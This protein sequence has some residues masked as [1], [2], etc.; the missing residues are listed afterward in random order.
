MCTHTC[1][2][3]AADQSPEPHSS[4]MWPFE[5]ICVSS[6][7]DSESNATS[8]NP[9]CLTP[10]PLPDPSHLGLS[11]HQRLFLWRVCCLSALGHQPPYTSDLRGEHSPTRAEAAMRGQAVW[12]KI[13]GW[14]SSHCGSGVKTASVTMR[15]RFLAS[16]KFKWLKDW[17]L[18]QAAA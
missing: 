16:L 8:L 12:T 1:T 3:L 5:I 17:A 14:G 13:H 2:I 18:L 6:M 15:V 11:G 9:L 10:S 4:C 7:Q